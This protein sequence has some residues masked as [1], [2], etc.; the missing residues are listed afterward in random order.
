MNI[1]QHYRVV[2]P[3]FF[4][5]IESTKGGE[6]IKTIDEAKQALEDWGVTSEDSEYYEF[7]KNKRALC[8]IVKVTTIIQELGDLKIKPLTHENSKHNAMVI[9]HLIDECSNLNTQ[10]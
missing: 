2:T 4:S 3:D 9:Q 5:D 7:W 6:P 10:E 8:K 1:K